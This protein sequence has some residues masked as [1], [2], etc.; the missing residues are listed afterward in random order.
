VDRVQH[1]YI[2]KVNCIDWL[3]ADVII[4][5]KGRLCVII[6]GAFDEILHVCTHMTSG[7]GALRHEAA[8]VA[9]RAAAGGSLTRTGSKGSNGSGGSKNSSSDNINDSLGTPASVHEPITGSTTQ[10]DIKSPALTIEEEEAKKGERVPLTPERRAALAE[11][12][13]KLA[14]EGLRVMAVAFAEVCYFP[15]HI[16]LT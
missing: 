9:R 2:V 4:D 10:G 6:I 13:L 12:N 5:L 8:A 14:A 7:L 15:L 11:L 1:S 3:P 16:H